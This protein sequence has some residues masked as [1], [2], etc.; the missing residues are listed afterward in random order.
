M[1]TIPPWNLRLRVM[2]YRKHAQ[3]ETSKNFQLGLFTPD[4]GH[5]EY[6]VAALATASLVVRVTETMPREPVL[7]DVCTA[8]MGW[9]FFESHARIPVFGDGN[10]IA[11]SVRILET[12][13]DCTDSARQPEVASR[14]LGSH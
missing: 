6:Y 5:F 13:K 11:Y 12:G 3:H 9:S 7:P 4:D 2:I 14:V 10:R 1:L 8:R